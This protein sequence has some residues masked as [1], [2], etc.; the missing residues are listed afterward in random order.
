VP[1]PIFLKGFLLILSP[2]ELDITA[3]YTA[4]GESGVSTMDVEVIQ[5]RKQ[6]QLVVADIPTEIPSD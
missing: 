1:F 6:E 2:V 5:P 4:R 3:V